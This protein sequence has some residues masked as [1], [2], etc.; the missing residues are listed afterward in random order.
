MAL[1]L[2]AFF[3]PSEVKDVRIE[4]AALVAEAAREYRATHGIPPASDDRVR[5]AAFGIDCQIGF[6][7]PGASLFVPGAVEDMQRAIAWLYRNLDKIT[8][9]HLS[10]DTH[11]VFQVFH[12]GFWRDGDGNPPAPLT[13]IFHEEVRARKWTPADHRHY[14]ACLEYTKKLEEGG[15]Y[16]LTIWPYHTLL[17]GVSHAVVPSL[18]EAAIFHALVREAPTRFETKGL[19]ELTE[20]YSVFSPEVTEVAGEQVGAF[21][22]DLFDALMRHDRVYV[23]GEAKS[24]CVLSTLRDLMERI[25]ARDPRLAEKVF[26]LEDAMS[27]VPAPPLDPLPP[28]LDFP[29]LADEGLSALAAKGMRIVRTTD[30]VLL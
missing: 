30:D 7:T 29:R 17:G 19:A 27:P 16:V 23:F 21:N 9:L 10:L 5:V 4:R 28:G 13:P 3:D 14:D 20:M 8:S 24:H 25:E 2:P 22:G 12:P 1:P 26:I 6:S 11:R 15:R 18:M